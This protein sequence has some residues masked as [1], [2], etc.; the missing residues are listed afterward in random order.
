MDLYTLQEKEFSIWVK[1]LKSKLYVVNLRQIINK[2]EKLQSQEM[3]QKN[4]KASIFLHSTL[5]QPTQHA[6]QTSDNLVSS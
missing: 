2:P 5:R 1:S 3:A 4:R 6:S